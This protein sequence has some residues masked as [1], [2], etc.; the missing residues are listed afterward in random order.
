MVRNY[1]VKRLEEY[2][3]NI[4]QVINIRF[5]GVSSTCPTTKIVLPHT[6][7]K[8]ANTGCL[9]VKLISHYPFECRLI[10]ITLNDRAYIH[11]SVVLVLRLENLLQMT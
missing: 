8:M 7:G 11:M 10:I 5:G 3:T 1:Y 4:D 6:C 9:N 2:Q